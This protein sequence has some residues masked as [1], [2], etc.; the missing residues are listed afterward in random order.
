MSGGAESNKGPKKRT[1]EYEEVGRTTPY[2]DWGGIEHGHAKIWPVTPTNTGAMSSRSIV[3]TGTARQQRKPSYHIHSCRSTPLYAG[4]WRCPCPICPVW[5]HCASAPTFAHGKVPSGHLSGCAPAPEAS[6]Q[7]PSLSTA[8]CRSSVAK[9]GAC[10]LSREK[11]L[12]IIAIRKRINPTGSHRFCHW[13]TRRRTCFW[14][15]SARFCRRIRLL[16]N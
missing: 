5:V 16:A 7:A 6:T 10:F 11:H 13:R 2:Y 12:R 3:I 8:R 4:N 14:L 15:R 9:S 1:L